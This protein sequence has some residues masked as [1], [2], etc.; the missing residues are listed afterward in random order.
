M[1]LYLM[2]SKLT[3]RGRARVKSAPD[4]ILEVNQEVEEKGAKV[5]SQYALLGEFDFATVLE[6]PDNWNMLRLAMDLGARGTIETSTYPALRIND[7]ISFMKAEPVENTWRDD[8]EAHPERDRKR[9]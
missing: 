2:L 3:E 6:A 1:A 7:F 9:R 8:A 4:R 5:I